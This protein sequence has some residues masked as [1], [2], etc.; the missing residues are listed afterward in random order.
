MVHNREPEDRMRKPPSERHRTRILRLSALVALLL[1]VGAASADEVKI[2]RPIE[3]SG[4]ITWLPLFI[5]GA[6]TVPVFLVLLVSSG[7]KRHLLERATPKAENPE[8]PPPLPLLA[9]LAIQK[10]GEKPAHHAPLLVPV[11][12]SSAISERPIRRPESGSRPRPARTPPPLPR[13]GNPLLQ[14][15]GPFDDVVMDLVDQMAAVLREILPPTWREGSCCIE[16]TQSQ[17]GLEPDSVVTN[18]DHPAA[19]VPLP[20]TFHR[21]ASRL[22]H[23]W[24]R[25]GQPF[26]KVRLDI[27]EQPGG[28]LGIRFQIVDP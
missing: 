14:L 18:P 8:E 27:F 21:L 16:V 12:I 28:A 11:T 1:F 22:V 23:H 17:W 9:S 26:P 7:W 25:D 10:L 24:T 19:N 4:G 2:E 13:G 5:F 6:V 3:P 20:P 15:R